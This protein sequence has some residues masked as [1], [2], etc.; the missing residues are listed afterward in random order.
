[1][2]IPINM[3]E[4]SFKYERHYGHLHSNVDLRAKRRGQVESNQHQGPI[5]SNQTK[6]DNF[7]TLMLN[8]FTKY[9]L[10]YII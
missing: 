1:M 5:I 4:L 10:I 7:C 9:N 8:I 3:T 6:V 2:W